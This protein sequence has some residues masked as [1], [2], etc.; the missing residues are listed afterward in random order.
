MQTSRTIK[1]TSGG[2]GGGGAVHIKHK[3]WDRTNSL[4]LQFNK[5]T[6]Q[7]PFIFMKGTSKLT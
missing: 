6:S 7:N 3:Q 5:F 2:G 1:E 4:I